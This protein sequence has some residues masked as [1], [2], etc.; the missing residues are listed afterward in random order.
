M[1]RQL[2]LWENSSRPLSQRTTV[3]DEKHELGQTVRTLLSDE[4]RYASI[5]RVS[6]VYEGSLN[7]RPC[8]TSTAQAKAFFAEY[9]ANHPAHDQEQFVVACLDVKH[10]V[11]CVVVVTVGTLDASLVHPREV[12]KPA[13][14]EGSSAIIL[15][16]NHPSGDISLSR[17]DREVTDRLTQAGELLGIQVLDHI[18]HGDGTNKVVSVREA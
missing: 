1:A 2:E 6:L 4:T 9:W 11:Q 10:R 12:F 18:V 3:S 5:K 13:I 14:I 15:S 16:H 17:E 8:L 7:G